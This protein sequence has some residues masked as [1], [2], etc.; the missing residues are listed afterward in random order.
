M[1]EE[2][3]S[4]NIMKDGELEIKWNVGL[5]FTVWCRQKEGV[6]IY[7]KLLCD[8]GWNG[9]AFTFFHPQKLYDVRVTQTGQNF[10]FLEELFPALFRRRKGIIHLLDSTHAAR[11]LC[12]EYLAI[13]TASEPCTSE[14]NAVLN[15]VGWL[16]FE[17]PTITD[18]GGIH[19]CRFTVDQYLLRS[20][21]LCT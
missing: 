1:E 15:I 14:F 7:Q 13:H 9:K 4:S 18:F 19:L 6:K 16:L 21:L 8:E 5:D 12:F 11:Y 3:S 17:S 20:T 2:E 10:E